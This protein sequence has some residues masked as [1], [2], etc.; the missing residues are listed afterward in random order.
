LSSLEEAAST[1]HYDT[2]PRTL[3]PWQGA[4]NF[5]R[6]EST[7]SAIGHGHALDCF[8]L[9]LRPTIRLAIQEYVIITATNDAVL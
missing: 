2:F 4:A 5:H 8:A 7:G 6:Q 1:R 9:G 3:S